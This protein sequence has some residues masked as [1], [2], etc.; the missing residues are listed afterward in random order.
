MQRLLVCA[1]GLFL[2]CACAPATGGLGDETESDAEAGD[3][4]GDGDGAPG[5]GDGMPGD[6]DGDGTPGDGDGDGDGTPGD[7]DGEPACT[8][9]D[10]ACD[11][12][13][14]SCDDGLV[15]KE[16]ACVLD[17]CGNSM[18]DGDEDCDDGND[19]DG[20]GCDNDCSRTTLSIHAGGVHTCALIEGGRVRCWGTANVGQL[21]YGNETV[22]GDNEPPSDAGDVPLI[23]QI[24][25]FDAGGLHNC[26]IFEDDVLRCWG[27]GAAGQLGYGNNMDLGDDEMLDMLV[28]VMLGGTASKI[29]LG[30]SHSCALVGTQVLCWGANNSGQLGVGNTMAVG[31]MNVPTDSMTVAFSSPIVMLE[32]GVSHTCAVTDA[33]ELYCWGNNANGQLGYGGDQNVGND[34]LPDSAGPV[35]VM[36]MGLGMNATISSLA[37]GKDHSCALFSTGQVLCWGR[38]NHGQLGQGNNVDWGDDPNEFPAML[39]PID[40]GGAVVTAITAGDD[41][42]CALIDDG[43]VRCWGRSNH[44]QLGQGNTNTIGND[45]M[46]VPVTVDLGGPAIQISAGIT[47][48]CAVLDD[49]T[50]RCWGEGGQGR[51]GYGNTNT[52]G[53]TEVPSS[54]ADPVS[55]LSM[56]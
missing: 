30:G 21:G 33:D 8:T 52:I 17:L 47:H 23:G 37:L 18:V 20:D 2:L 24:L 25:Q 27:A 38:N 50:V 41:F 45:A 48:V 42:S 5:D 22:I 31:S 26:G 12:S 15:C 32:A 3:G 4:D 34:E 53:D 35:D 49:Y 1:P 16:G 36:S 7:G 19:M 28:G 51:L 40:F 56:P 14:G 54:L 11:G 46:E 10:C 29:S 55:V 13:P 9:L 43:S 6:G 44:G 39:A